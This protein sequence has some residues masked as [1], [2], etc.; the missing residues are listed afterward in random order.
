LNDALKV[1]AGM[2]VNLFAQGA[3]LG[4]IDNY[5][6]RL[7]ANDQA[8]STGGRALTST[9]VSQ[10]DNTQ[11][12]DIAYQNSHKPILQRLFSPYDANSALAKVIDYTPSINQF[13][14]II[15]S[16]PARIGSS[17]SSML[18]L[19]F[20]K[21]SAAQTYNY[22]F[23]EYGFSQ[24]EQNDSLFN[25]PDENAAIVEPQLDQL[26]TKYGSCFSMTVAPD[27]SNSD[28]L[29]LQTDDA[30][31]YYVVSKKPECNDGSQMLLRY[32]FYLADAVTT[33]S[34]SCFEGDENF[35]SQLGF[36]VSSAPTEAATGAT[37]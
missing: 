11:S 32:R 3:E 28:G 25:N 14:T 18:S 6:S 20:H 7:A 1:A 29:V 9:E 5:G 33:A 23:P 2:S 8:L 13:S 17:F 15:G 36:D 24:A 4:N 34:L 35:C 12:Q 19:P 27:S 30:V 31:N 22:G 21:A 16:L 26:N 37:P 10:L